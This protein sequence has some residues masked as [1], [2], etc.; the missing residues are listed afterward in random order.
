MKK[1][2]ALS[3]AAVLTLT[4]C[5]AKNDQPKENGST[6]DDKVVIK[7]MSGGAGYWESAL[8]PVVEAYNA[9]QD[10][11][12]VQV[13]YYQYDQLLQNV[14][15]KFGAKSKDYDI[16][17]VDAPL[18]AAYSDRGY[19]M[20]LNDYFTN[21]EINLFVESEITA[22]TWDNKFMA[23]PLN[24]SSQLL[25]YN[26]GLLKEAGIS[27][28]GQTPEERLSWEEVVEMSK[29]V[30][31][32]VD[33]DGTKGI[34]GVMFEQVGRAY[35]MLTLP[36]S[37]GEPSIGEDGYTVDGV[38]NSEGWKKSLAF[39]QNLYNDG[40]SARG[41][42]AE[43]VASNYTSGNVVF[44]IGATWTEGGAQAAGLDYGFAPCPYFEGYEDSV[45]TAT[46]SWHIGINAYTEKS[47]AAADFVKYLTIGEGEKWNQAAGN[48]SSLKSAVDAVINDENSSPVMKLAAYE[49]A[50]TGYPR[51]VTPAY[52][53]YETAINQMFEDIRNGADIDASLEA[54]ISQINTA[55]KKYQ[56]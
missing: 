46:G 29:K 17:T 21:D 14:E 23:A 52:S 24:N 27:L 12:E 55:C 15:V 13:D 51:P 26:A 10:K 43:E 42:T 1:F 16:V 41:V 56:K 38:I 18:V 53:E 25:W 49:T 50:N 19:I 54:T 37:L 5:G 31:E 9:S 48:V 32:T 39:Y 22:S 40:I 3:L 34:M 44:M 35:Q 2:L 8:N 30:K 11:V 47:E 36:N 6:G 28:P 45:A 20:P 7:M 33:P 4:G